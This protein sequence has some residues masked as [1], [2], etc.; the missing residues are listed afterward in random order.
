MS[1]STDKS[2]HNAHSPNG[3][4]IGLSQIRW[5][6]HLSVS[7]EDPCA[8][9]LRNGIQSF[10]PGHHCRGVAEPIGDLD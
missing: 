5:L 9:V 8:I 6:D 10:F 4:P 7:I 1:Q 2:G 3:R